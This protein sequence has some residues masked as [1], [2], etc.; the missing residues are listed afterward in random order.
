MMG[1]DFG[2]PRSW[3]APAFQRAWGF[4]THHSGFSAFSLCF[5][6]FSILMAVLACFEAV[7][8]LPGKR[9]QLP[10]PAAASPR[11]AI[12]AAS[13]ASLL[14]SLCSPESHLDY[15]ERN[16]RESA[17]LGPAKQSGELGWSVLRG[18]TLFFLI[19]PTPRAP[20]GHTTHMGFH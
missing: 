12:P 10:P 11:R 6:L 1:G 20:L 7:S 17:R 5:P 8:R 15:E 13:L 9:G 2:L 3:P 16:G 4:R 14:R 19:L 18:P